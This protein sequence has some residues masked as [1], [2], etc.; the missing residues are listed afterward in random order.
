MKCKTKTDYTY[1]SVAQ[2]FKTKTDYIY[3][4]VANTSTSKLAPKALALPNEP[5]A[6][7]PSGKISPWNSGPAVFGMAEFT[8]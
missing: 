7:L 6:G 4:S 2:A 8:P 5:G 3:K 1:K